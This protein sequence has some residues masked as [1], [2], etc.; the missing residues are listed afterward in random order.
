MTTLESLTRH[1]L[2]NAVE[3]TRCALAAKT[4]DGRRYWLDYA[5]SDLSR[6]WKLAR[7]TNNRRAMAS[8][9]R[10]RNWIRAAG[11]KLSPS[12]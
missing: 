11:L 5:R 8:V 9:C 12:S 7:R 4:D 2:R 3:M 6:A 10:M 1:W